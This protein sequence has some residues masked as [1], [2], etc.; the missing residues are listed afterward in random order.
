[1][2][3]DNLGYDG[4]GVR[5]AVIDTGIYDHPDLNVVLH[6]NFINGESPVDTFDYVGH[7]TH[8]AG[9]IG[10]DGGGSSGVYRGVAPGVS[11][12]SAKAGDLSGL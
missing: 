11:L 10:S 12:I 2:G 9:I 8:V 4:S 1:M 7:G 5:V 6:E 3:A